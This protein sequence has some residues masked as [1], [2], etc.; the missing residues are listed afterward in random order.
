M[1]IWGVWERNQP[2]GGRRTKTDEDW[3]LPATRELPMDAETP[4]GAGAEPMELQDDFDV[5][6]DPVEEPEEA[7]FRSK[8]YF[9]ELYARTP[10][11]ARE[12]ANVDRS[13]PRGT[14]GAP[15]S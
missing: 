10:P 11:A 1:P 15:D 8:A 6:V 4:A 2:T 14:A 3:S 12:S 9:P 5:G 7:G 13:P